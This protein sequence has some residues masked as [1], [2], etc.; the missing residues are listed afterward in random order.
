MRD[1]DESGELRRQSDD[2]KSSNINALELLKEGSASQPKQNDF[3]NLGNR[4]NT[5]LNSSDVFDINYDIFQNIM[6]QPSKEAPDAPPSNA[7]DE[8]RLRLEK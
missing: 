4:W 1:L 7:P 5:D 8:E 6:N 3:F 2:E